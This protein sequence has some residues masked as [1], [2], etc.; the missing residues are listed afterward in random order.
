M[1]SVRCENAA[2]ADFLKDV[3]QKAG[4]ALAC[5]GAAALVVVSAALVK[6]RS[7]GAHVVACGAERMTDDVT[8]VGRND[9]DDSD[10]EFIGFT[11]AENKNAEIDKLIADE[12]ASK[13]TVT[14]IVM[15][16]NDWINADD[17]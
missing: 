10:D 2:V 11:F 3:G 7:H 14:N 16:N 13:G 17:I 15:D 5:D 8:R 12:L 1:I 4:V 9:D 6:L